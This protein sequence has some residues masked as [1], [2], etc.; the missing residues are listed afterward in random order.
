V[1][2]SIP[3]CPLN[4]AADA[5]RIRQVVSNLLANAVKFTPAG[6]RIDLIVEA[7]VRRC[8]T[9]S[10]H[11]SWYRPRPAPAHLRD[12]S[13]ATGRARAWVSASP[14]SRASSNA[15]RL[16]RG[17]ERRSRARQ[18]VR[19][20]A[21]FVTTRGN[22]ILRFRNGPRRN[23]SFDAPSASSPTCSPICSEARPQL[24]V[25]DDF[26]K[27]LLLANRRFSPRSAAPA[28]QS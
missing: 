2:S 5:T 3:D 20:H 12:V 14:W 10:R 11:R 8:D 28:T 15:G 4:V 13:R 1:S 24:A 9:R 22:V 16:G 7:A 26:C 19:G 27:R 25:R 23:Y 17:R 18:R 21:A 6:G